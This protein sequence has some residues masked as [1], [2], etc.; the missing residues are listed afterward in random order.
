MQSYQAYLLVAM[1]LHT[2][3]FIDR[4]FHS[5]TEYLAAIS[6]WQA[7]Y[8]L[9]P[10][11]ADLRPLISRY[12]ETFRAI[13]CEFLQQ[14]PVSPPEVPAYFSTES[15]KRNVA[16]AARRYAL[17]IQ[18]RGVHI[19]LSDATTKEQHVDLALRVRH[20][21]LLIEEVLEPPWAYVFSQFEASFRFRSC[22]ATVAAAISFRETMMKWV[23]KVAQ[24][25]E[26]LRVK[27]S[28]FMPPTAKEVAEHI[29]V[30]LFYMLLQVVE[31]PHPEVAFRF[32]LGAPI[33]G[34]F[35][36][37]ALPARLKRG[38]PLTD[39]NIRHV[40]AQSYRACLRVDST[41]SDDGGV[42]SMKK[43]RNDFASG[44]LVGPFPEFH[45]MVAGMEAEVRRNP[46]CEHFIA[47]PE[48]V[49][50][51]PQFAIEESHSTI[52]EAEGVEK[53]VKVRNIWNGKPPN[54]LT[55]SYNTYIPNNHSDFSVIVLRWVTLFMAFAIAFD[56]QAWPSDFSSAYR[57]CPL[58]AL[59]ILVSGTCF[60]NYE[61]DR[62]EWAFYRSLPFGS[63]LAPAGWSEV[64]HALCFLMAFAF[65]AILTHCVDDVC[66][67]ELRELAE[68]SRAIFIELCN[69][70]GLKLDMKKTLA[71]CT[72]LIYLGLNIILPCRYLGVDRVFT[73]S[74]PKQRRIR[75]V[76]YMKGIINDCML[77]PG[78]S[79]SHRG[80]LFFY[81]FWD[82]ESRSYLSEFAARQYSDSGDFS[83][84]PE[85]RQAIEYFL[86]LLNSPRFLQGFSPETL[87]NRLT[88]ILYTDGAL[89]GEG[90]SAIKGVGG[91]LFLPPNQTPWSFDENLPWSFGELL[92]L[93][94]P[95]FERI[96]PIEM[97]AIL[98]AIH[99]FGEDM[100]G[101]A[102]LFFVD[103]THAI[104][105]LLKRSA[106]VR[107]EPR[108]HGVKRQRYDDNDQQ[109]SHYQRFLELPK[110]FRRFMNEQARAIWSA[111]TF[112]DLLVWFEYVKTD[113][114]V[115][116]PPSRGESL[117]CPGCSI[118]ARDYVS[119]HKLP[120][121][122]YQ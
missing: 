2:Y 23:R 96:A 24:E 57:Q 52:E 3:R 82:Q 108:E 78:D 118:R 107:E 33:L 81:S 77:T 67:T 116:D 47:D 73:L 74:V 54:K 114:N 49:I 63:S 32:F 111:I 66:C 16:A 99:L 9:G 30:P 122:P 92:P 75:L 60:W 106:T 13:Q 101:R 28:V 117:P 19:P 120:V 103:N 44:S 113:C 71:P 41:L 72:E 4:E 42:E 21:A 65:L 37:P 105:C 36:S 102:V 45:Y 59:H 95:N 53:A 38:L 100:R 22:N 11:V 91:V 86:A 119:Y 94:V 115:A 90:D 55:T 85:L 46:G 88:C 68:S 27:H 97:E 83:L 80:R 31:Y 79:A 35:A 109:Y 50:A 40:A 121:D 1:M 43:M 56:L 12:Q 15:Q 26:P 39:E 48:L 104:G 84:T 70:I 14:P 87:L 5:F 29:H 20:P 69:L 112:Y 58:E 62:R 64:V 10:L 17:G 110:P 6:S 51:V 98:R 34:D 25:L 89:E 8:Q 7:K 76:A 18:A 61:T 93:D